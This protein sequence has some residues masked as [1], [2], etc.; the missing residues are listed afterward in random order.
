MTIGKGFRSG[1]MAVLAAVLLLPAVGWAGRSG[2]SFTAQE[3]EIWRQRAQSGPYKS[4]GDVS[5][6]SPG[7]WD[8]IVA[9]R[10]AFASN[11]SNGRW[12]SGPQDG[13]NGGCVSQPIAGN[14]PP[15][16][17][18]T[19][20]A[21]RLRDA[22]F[23]NLVMGATTDHA[24]IKSELLWLV[25]QSWAQ[26]GDPN[27][28][29]C[30]GLM[31]DVSPSF[32]ITAWLTRILFAYDYIGRNAFTQAELDKI[33]RWLFDAAD[34]W[35][36][37]V[38]VSLD[39]L[40]VDRWSG[41]HALT[42]SCANFTTP[43]AGAP[44]GIANVAKYYNNR[45]GSNIR[46]SALAG[47]YLERNGRDYTGGRYG[48]LKDIVTSGG[49]YVREFV[50]FSL[51]PQGFVGDFERRSELPDLGWAYSGS[52][53]AQPQLIADIYARAGDPSL[54]EYSTKLGA[55]GT[56][57]AVQD[58]G[59][60]DGQPRD[61]KFALQSHL[62]YITDVYARYWPS[63][64]NDDYRIDGRNPRS[65]SSWN[66]IRDTFSVHSN[67][68]FKDSFIQDS[69]T[70]NHPKAVAYPANPAHAG[71]PAWQGDASIFPA[72]L[73]MYSQMEGAVWP[74][75]GTGEDGESVRPNPPV[76]TSVK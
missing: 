44:V 29:W 63:A 28:I 33:D 42:G 74:Y 53:I 2:L 34:F 31:W 67:V 19:D 46:F 7:D 66:D 9:N 50:R 60:R 68:Y 48:T 71:G 24:A 6:N 16:W 18:S 3:V 47:K 14:Q 37:D 30:F 70:R 20:W 22:A 32:K 62:K 21:I 25:N 43:Y 55:C 54:Y 15:D 40:F 57:G 51:F 8:R 61:L 49:L 1:R 4:A 52:A 17:G 65:G 35:R 26:F 27:G 76:L 45:R 36:R 13:V 69:Y 39:K 11:P 10:N 75:A 23:H 59:D 56:E 38:D 72:M 73:F 41:N 5:T 12:T 64:G 58:G